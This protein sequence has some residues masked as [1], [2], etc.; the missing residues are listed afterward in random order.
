LLAGHAMAITCK[1]ESP[2]GNVECIAPQ[3][4]PWS[5]DSSNH[6]RGPT[7]HPPVDTLAE[8]ASNATAEIAEYFGSA[9]CSFDYQ[10]TSVPFASTH[11]T[12]GI[13]DIERIQYYMEGTA[14]WSGSS[15]PCAM[16]QGERVQIDRTRKVFCPSGWSGSWSAD[17]GWF[18]FRESHSPRCVGQCAAGA[19]TAAA[20]NAAGPQNTRDPGWVG[21]GLYVHTLDKFHS[22]VDWSSS[23]V[24][25]FTL[26]RN[27]LS[28]GFPRLPRASTA[29]EGLGGYWRTTFNTR[30]ESFSNGAT[31]SKVA[32]RNDGSVLYFYRSGSVWAGRPEQTATLVDLIRGGIA[33]GWR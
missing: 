17:Q 1:H 31:S 26:R 2:T 21:D 30:L 32:L 10:V 24:R 14:W 23:G 27:Y 25:P 6:H 11:S 13:S 29:D 9:F 15:A 20:P 4:G 8:A 12:W 22:E 19:T 18:C 16:G 5:Y 3:Q 28:T 7:V 33:T